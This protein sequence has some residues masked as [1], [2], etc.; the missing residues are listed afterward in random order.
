MAFFFAIYYVG[1]NRNLFQDV[2]KIYTVFPD[3]KGLN[4]G[5]NVRY[6]GIN[7]GTVSGI[8]IKNDTTVRVEISVQSDYA[9]FIK[10]DSKVEISNDGLMG[11]KIL[12]IHHGSTDSPSVKEFSTLNSFKTINVEDIVNEAT[13]I[14][15]NARD[16][17][18]MLLEVSSHLQSGKGDLGKLIYD[19]SLTHNLNNTMRNL[20]TTSGN[21]KDITEHIRAGNGDLGSLVYNDSLTNSLQKSFDEFAKASENITRISK[22]LDTA[23]ININEGQGI[24]HTLIY[25]STFIQHADSTL[26]N[27]NQ[28]IDEITRTFTAIKNSWIINLFGGKDKKSNKK[29][30]DKQDSESEE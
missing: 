30:E 23:A 12:I 11:S 6:S 18:E 1:K 15:K 27:L 26:T 20:M 16:A 7:V 14:I 2:T 3:I 4:R 19:T 13:K 29:Q 28:G 9:K 24:L 5:N 25:D 21:T 17:T 22:S 10:E 8:T